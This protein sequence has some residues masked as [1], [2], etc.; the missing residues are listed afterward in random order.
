MSSPSIV[1]MGKSSITWSMV[2]SV[3]IILA[4]VLAIVVPP[5][6][7]IVATV[8]IGWL[9]VFCGVVHLMIGWHL[10]KVGGL[11]WAILLG[12]AYLLAGIY[13]L[14]H[15][16]AGLAALTLAL[17]AYLFVEAILEFALAWKLRPVGGSGWLAFDGVVTL[18]FSILIW[19]TWPSSSA[20]VIGTLV[21]VSMIFS[22]A[23]RVAVLSA[24][25]RVIPQLA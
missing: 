23:S 22:G 17:G 25:R 7:G 21:G 11:A 2:L 20:W 13:I 6:A 3:L 5:A 14:L 18:I 15:P 19:T 24:A 1:D 16:V 12:I 10:R 9:L 8:L 4:G